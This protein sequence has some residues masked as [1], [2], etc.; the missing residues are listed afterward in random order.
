MGML[1][2]GRRIVAGVGFGSEG[3]PCTREPRHRG[4]CSAN[5][6]TLHRVRAAAQEHELA[7]LALEL[8]LSRAETLLA[9]VRAAARNV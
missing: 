2:C 3:A 8:G 1:L 4:R 5:A 7:E 9:R 6:P